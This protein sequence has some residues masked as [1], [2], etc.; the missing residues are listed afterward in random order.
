MIITSKIEN[1]KAYLK[2][3]WEDKTAQAVLIQIQD[4]EKKEVFRCL[5]PF[6]EEEPAGAILLHPHLWNST[7]AP[8]LYHVTAHFISSEGKIVESQTHFLALRTLE[9]LEGKGW[10]LNGQPFAIRAVK[11]DAGKLLKV[12]GVLS[13]LEELRN[14]GANAL[15]LPENGCTEE[16]AQVCA[17]MGFLIFEDALRGDILP[18]SCSQL[19]LTKPPFFTDLYYCCKAKWSREGFVYISMESICQK[20]NGTLSMKVYSNLKKTA[21]YIDGV[22]FEFMT[23]EQEYLF[24]EIPVKKYPVMLTAEAGECRMAVTLYE[25]TQNFHKAVTYF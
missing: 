23:G 22:L 6:S 1:G 5:Y 14:M 16:F 24:E 17:E 10:F 25:R 21:L 9:E 11:W 4:A 7:E 2:F 20:D 18:P 3:D 15:Y 19:F 13:V 8:Y 12:R